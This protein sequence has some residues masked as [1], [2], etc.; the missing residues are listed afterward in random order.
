MA[1]QRAAGEAFCGTLNAQLSPSA[2]RPILLAANAALVALM[3]NT[4]SAAATISMVNLM[5]R[6]SPNV[7]RSEPGSNNSI[8][9]GSVQCVVRSLQKSHGC[10]AQRGVPGRF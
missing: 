8:K 2:L 1:A 5:A 3:Q 6:P 10:I 9:P 4:R 7:A